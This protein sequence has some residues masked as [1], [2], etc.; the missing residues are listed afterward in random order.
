M[1]DIER[2]I[3]TKPNQKKIH[4]NHARKIDVFE[5]KTKIKLNTLPTCLPRFVFFHINIFFP[6][7]LFI[8]ELISRCL[9]THTNVPN[10]GFHPFYLSDIITNFLVLF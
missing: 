3:K 9:H 6:S 5:K 2:L 7:I 1:I 10:G 4:Y 8:D